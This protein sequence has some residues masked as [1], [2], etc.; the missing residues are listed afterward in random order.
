M[1]SRWAVFISGRGS[2]LQ[3]LLDQQE[4]FPISLVVSSRA[5]APGL[6]RA[7]RFGVTT[8]VM[9]KQSSDPWKGLQNILHERGIAKI[10]LLGFMKIIPEEFLR[11][12]PKIFNLHPSLLPEF[13]GLHAFE[14]SWVD[15]ES[16][17][18]SL[19]R[20]TPGL[21]EGPVVLQNKICFWTRSQRESIAVNSSEVQ[22]FLRSSEQELLRRASGRNMVLA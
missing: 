5:S 6:Q 3:S 14:R 21:D 1:R 17:G 12:F 10:L 9:E 19:H 18:V 22:R 15:G 4:L 8:Y 7:K 13:K 16:L 20:V 11:G 2:N